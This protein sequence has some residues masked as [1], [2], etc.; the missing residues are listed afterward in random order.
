MISLDSIL[1]RG[2]NYY[3]QVFLKECQYNEQ[4]VIRHIIN[5]LENYSDDS[6]EEL[7]KAKYQDVF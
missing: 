3:L 6:D 4:R 7:I 2:E 1:K 5:D